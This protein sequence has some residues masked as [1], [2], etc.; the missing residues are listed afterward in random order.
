MQS[1][2]SAL[3]IITFV[4]INIIALCSSANVPDNGYVNPPPPPADSYDVPDNGYV[5]PPPP[6]ADSYDVPDNGYVNPP[7]APADSY[8]VPGYS[9]V[10]GI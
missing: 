3:S 2:V 10:K 7:P 8:D 9:E 1:F 6:P 4:I 5:N